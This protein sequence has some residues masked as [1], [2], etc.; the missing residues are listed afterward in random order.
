MYSDDGRALLELN[1]ISPAVRLSQ[2]APVGDDQPSGGMAQRFPPALQALYGGQLHPATLFAA[3]L[4]EVVILIRVPPASHLM[5]RPVA[6]DIPKISHL[7][8]GDQYR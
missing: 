1:P 8:I 6:V 2:E 3:L 7:Q 5:S 4:S